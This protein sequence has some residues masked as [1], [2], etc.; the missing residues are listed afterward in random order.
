VTKDE[1]VDLFL[2]ETENTPDG[3][4]AAQLDLF[5]DVT[6][7]TA[8]RRKAFTAVFTE[9]DEDD[10]GGPLRPPPPSPP[11]RSCAGPSRLALLVACAQCRRAH[12][13]ALGASG[14]C[15]RT[16]AARYAKRVS[17]Y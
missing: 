4:F 17:G 2:K 6:R 1:L 7:L 8:E 9:V 13:R 11:P 10:S 16:D 12:P 3:D 14:W 15:R 5:Y